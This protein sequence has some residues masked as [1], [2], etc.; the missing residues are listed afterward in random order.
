MKKVALGTALAMMLAL[1]PVLFVGSASAVVGSSTVRVINGQPDGGGPAIDVYFDGIKLVNDLGL[2]QGIDITVNADNPLVSACSAGS[3]GVEADG[4]CLDSDQIGTPNFPVAIGDGG[5]YTLVILGDLDGPLEDPLGPD[6]II[7]TNDLGPTGL[8]EARYTVHN[9]VGL[10]IDVCINGVKV[11]TALP[12]GQT[13]TVSVTAVQGA[14]YA[15]VVPSTGGPAGCPTP[16]AQVNF[17]A[18]TNFVQTVAASDDPTCA[19]GCVQVLFV[20]EG[21]VPNNP[22]TVTF[23]NTVLSLA[24]V[25]AEL[26]ALIGNVDPTSTTTIIN[27]QPS[28]QAMMDFVNNTTVI[29]NAGDASVPPE[30][31]SAW[32]TATAGLRLLLQTFKLAG[33]D[34][35]NLPPSAVEML[36]EG[37]NGFVI[38][39]VPPDLDVLGATTALTAFFVDVCNSVLPPPPPPPVVNPP[40]QPVVQVVTVQPRFT[41]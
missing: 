1:V 20:G 37:A 26:Q 2:G 27:T 19:A 10:P 12:F 30:I 14:D 22:S 33:Y 35:S 8:N 21:T 24:G 29:L 32:A 31:A 38:P 7:F 17:V 9:V 13:A 36:V 4:D 18:G 40:V 23:C 16:Q 39:G 28:V 11:V 5:N 25:G 41:G 6:P 15:I 3:T 34:L